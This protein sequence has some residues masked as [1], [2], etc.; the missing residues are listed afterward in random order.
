MIRLLIMIVMLAL[1]LPAF[2]KDKILEIQE[3]T[4]KG[5]IKAWLVEDKTLPII[6]IQFSFKGA[7]AVNNPEEKQGLS[8]LLSNTMDEG[9]GDLDSQS[10]QKILNDHSISIGFSSGRDNFSG[11]VETLS[12]HKE[13]AFNLLE[14]ALNQTRFDEEPFNRMR[15]KNI[16]R[17]KSSKSR[18]NWISAR[19]F[20]ALAYEGHPYAYNSGGT[21]STL[22]QITQDDLRQFQ[23][24]FLTQDRL[25]VSA[26]GNINPKE[27]SKLLD[28]LFGKLPKTG[29]TNNITDIEIQNT[30]NQFLFY[31]DIP[32]SIITLAMPSID[33]KDP[34]YYALLV[35]NHIF[36]ASGFGSRLMEEAREKRGLTY[37]IYSDVTVQDFTKYFS[38]STSTKNETAKEMLDIIKEEMKIF[39]SDGVSAEEI[40]NAQSYIT[41]SLPLAMT[42]TG[43]IAG[44]LLNLQV[45]DR[46]QTY[47]EDFIEKINAI[48]A[49]DVMRVAKRVLK[50]DEIFTII[51]GN[52]EGVGQIQN[53]EELPHVE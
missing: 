37:G 41:G 15:D 38:V 46:P 47:L 45:K 53:I 28:D 36:G 5:G 13:K 44:V 32:Q 22:P 33:D 39:T 20:N 27:L 24:D 7:G 50:P 23:K 35:M 25:H 52:P 26:S 42:S 3:V 34:D 9:A 18:P 2:A 40:D 29:K 49:N 6:S 8:R 11:H 17:I 30:G 43:S 14:L 1:P 31:K 19:L 21:L 16:M 51:V 10:F 12:R 4:S 48:T